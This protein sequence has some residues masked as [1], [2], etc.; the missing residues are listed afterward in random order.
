MEPDSNHSLDEYLE[1]NPNLKEDWEKYRKLP[2]DRRVTTRTARFLRKARLDELPQIWNIFVGDMS[3]VGPRPILE[4]EVSHFE[5]GYT[6]GIF[7]RSP[8]AHWP[9]A[10]EWSK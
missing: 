3:L 8:E 7:V 4:D 1:Q 9:I 2:K 6:Q 10:G 5:E